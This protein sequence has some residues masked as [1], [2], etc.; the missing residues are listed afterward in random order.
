MAIQQ[1]GQ[2]N[3]GGITLAQRIGRLKGEILAHA[4]PVEVLGITG[5]NKPI[6]ANSGDTVVFRRF[7]PYGGMDNK[8]I[9]GANVGTYASSQITTEGV[10]PAAD[11]ITAVDITVT[12]QQYSVLY[13]LTD[14]T[15]DMYEDDL[16]SE[17]KKQTGERV[18]LIRE[19][20]RYGALKGA[21]NVYY[22]GTGV[23]KVT[24]N[25]AVGLNLLR[26]ITRGLKANHAKMITS[27]L[28]PSPNFATAP[29][30]AS[31]LVFTSTDMEPGIRDIPGFKHISEYANRKPVHELEFG[32]AENFRF[33]TSPELAP[34]ID[35][36][37]A[38][39]A[40]GLAST[41]GANIDLYPMIITGE[42]A[43]GSVALRGKDSVDPTYIPP[44]Q[45][46][47]N[48]PLGQRGYI[49]AK[50][51]AASVLLNQGRMAVL[52]SGTPAL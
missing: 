28:A 48:D 52:W 4:I 19:M 51:Y 2:A 9:T 22:A 42:D 11:T 27:I 26:K 49:G 30:E 14:K 46:D 6:P 25:G 37:A 17:M 23:S 7:L 10:T 29:V 20:I 24:T 35:A 33:I 34:E 31:Y 39:G 47:K 21:T 18:G 40:T 12:L 32:S 36:G 38:V 15:A 50:F 3:A 5:M 41:G 1:F 44:G 45:K 16:P 8:F 43:W 13:S